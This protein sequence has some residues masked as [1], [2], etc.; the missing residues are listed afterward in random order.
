MSR[1]RVLRKALVFLP[2]VLLSLS[3]CAYSLGAWRE[4]ASGDDPFVKFMVCGDSLQVDVSEGF[5]FQLL[6]AFDKNGPRISG[7]GYAISASVSPNDK[8]GERINLTGTEPPGGFKKEWGQGGAWLRYW[9]AEEFYIQERAA[10]IAWWRPWTFP[11]EETLHI[12][13]FLLGEE[14]DGKRTLGIALVLFAYI[15][16]EEASNYPS[17]LCSLSLDFEWTGED[18]IGILTE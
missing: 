6:T 5:S 7:C 2:V 10:D 12:P 18:E 11:F 16:G 8:E 1:T 15:P 3:S 14:G 4:V 13:R 9:E 17:T